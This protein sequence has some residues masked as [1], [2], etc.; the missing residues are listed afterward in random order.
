ML[1][2]NQSLVYNN[3]Q[4]AEHVSGI[5]LAGGKSKRMGLDKRF[6]EYR[7]RNLINITLERLRNVADEV[8]LVTAEP[9]DLGVDDV[10][11][12]HDIRP[13]MGPL[14]GIY[15]GL[16]IITNQHAIVNPVDTPNVT[17][18]LLEYM[19]N[20]SCDFDVVMPRRGDKLEP[21]IACYSKNVIPVIDNIIEEGLKPAPH[22]L[23]A[24]T[25]GLKVRILE[26]SEILEFGNPDILFANINFP[27]DL[28]ISEC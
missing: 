25:N 12:A 9:E 19:I 10:V 2:Y 3:T 7:G 22:M 6:I 27:Q 21:L 26:E 15:S 17:E 24:K 5:L 20:I 11:S 28:P 1:S 8:V 4:M 13:G 23:A 18:K 14:M 16:I